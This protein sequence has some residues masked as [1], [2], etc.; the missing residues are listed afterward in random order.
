MDWSVAEKQERAA[1]QRIVAVLLALADLCDLASARPVPVRAFVLWLL[2]PAEGLARDFIFGTPDPAS[3]EPASLGPARNA[4]EDARRLAQSFRA[5]ACA[6]REAF[7]FGAEA[8]QVGPAV[9]LPVFA[10]RLAAILGCDA[11]LGVAGR[12]DT[13]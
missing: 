8:R 12:H 10:S 3:I 13:S 9:S 6:L 11:G 7:A 1:V 5:L 2:R 4:P